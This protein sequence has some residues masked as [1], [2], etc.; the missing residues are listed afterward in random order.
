M[1]FRSPYGFRL[2]P[3]LCVSSLRSPRP[4]LALRSARLAGVVG[5]GAGQNAG[6]PRGRLFTIVNSRPSS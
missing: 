2:T 5:A 4:A 3:D 1:F 6:M